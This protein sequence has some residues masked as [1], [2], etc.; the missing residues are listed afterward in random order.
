[1]AE[2]ITKERLKEIADEY[3]V[4]A[5]IGIALRQLLAYRES[6]ALARSIADALFT[7]GAGKIAETLVLEL[8]DGCNGGGWCRAAVEG[9]I[10][11]ELEAIGE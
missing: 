9:V 3:E 7:N 4:E 11:R 2:R 6:G 5:E 8:A 10:E 1:M